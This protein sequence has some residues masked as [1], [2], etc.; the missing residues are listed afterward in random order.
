M[1]SVS[2]RL[3]QILG[4]VGSWN[5][6]VG[7]QMSNCV[8]LPVDKLGKELNCLEERV[9]APFHQSDADLEEA[10]TRFAKVHR[11]D[12]G[13]KVEELNNDVFF[14]KRNFHEV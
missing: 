10:E 11:K 4:E 5:E 12:S 2:T 3:H 14:A 6:I 7:Q 9:G 13:R 8:L 1:A